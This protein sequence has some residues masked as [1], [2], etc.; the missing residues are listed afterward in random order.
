MMEK[1]TKTVFIADDGQ[2]FDT[3]QECVNYEDK[4]HWLN[5]IYDELK[6]ADESDIYDWIIKNTKGFVE[7]EQ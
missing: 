4:K 7:V 3:E 1:V 6:Y 5:V 2:E